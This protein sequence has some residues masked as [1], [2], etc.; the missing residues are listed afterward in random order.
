MKSMHVALLMVA[1]GLAALASETR[2]AERL[3]WFGTYTNPTTKSE[4]IYVARFDDERGTLTQPVLAA[5]ANNPSFLA[6]H[7]RLPVL[8]AVAEVAEVDGNAGGAVAAFAIDEKT[9][10]LAARGAAS[11]GGSYPCHVAV[12]PQGTVVLVANYGGGSAACLRLTAEGHLEP[13]V[14]DGSP[15][16]LLQHTYDRSGERGFN[17]TKQAAAHAHSADVSPTGQHTVVCDLGL[18]RVF[19][20]AIDRERGTLA[21]RFSVPLEPGAGPRHVALHPDGRRAWCVNELDF[22]V[23]GFRLSPDCGL[24]VGDSFSTLPADVTDRT[25]FSCAEIAVH[26]NGRFLYASTRGHDSIA[27]FRIVDDTPDLEWLGVEP[28]R[29]RAPRHFAI[30]PTGR[31]LLAAGH[32]SDTVAVFAIN[33]DTGR[34]TFT[35]HSIEVPSPV[36]ILFGRRRD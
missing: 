16:G 34:L 15:A 3:V 12:D 1:G 19:L 4:G 23:T 6:L 20:H 35:G 29:G 9:G 30:D 7:P 31:F 22:T 28:I 26:P 2:A 21:P 14:A 10:G 33:P 13:I 17:P 18:D 5:A 11:T 25:G 27:M 32:H 24:A 36:C 8:Y